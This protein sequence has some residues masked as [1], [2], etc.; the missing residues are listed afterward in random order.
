MEALQRRIS[1]DREKGRYIQPQEIEDYL[2]DFFQRE[3]PGSEVM[4]NTPAE[5]CVTLRLETER[6][7][8]PA[9][10]S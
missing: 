5:G 8:P 4:Q 6:M 3:F 1:E 10:S 7:W 9:A 2:F